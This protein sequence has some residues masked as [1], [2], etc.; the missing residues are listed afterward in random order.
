MLNAQHP[1]LT[2]VVEETRQQLD[3]VLVRFQMQM[4]VLRSAFT[5][6]VQG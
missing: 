5:A 4:T 6:N 1:A 3:N 2:A